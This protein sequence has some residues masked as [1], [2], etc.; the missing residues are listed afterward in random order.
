[1]Y[2]GKVPGGKF[3]ISSGDG[4][5]YRQDDFRVQRRTQD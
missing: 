5:L 3:F 1:M 2:E 4:E